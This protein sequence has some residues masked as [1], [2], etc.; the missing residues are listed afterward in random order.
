MRQGVVDP[1]FTFTA[2]IDILHVPYKGAGPAIA[3]VV[4]GHVDMIFINP[5]LVLGHVTTGKLRPL[6]TIGNDRW[7]KM[8]QVPTF[9][10][11][12][13]PSIDLHGIWTIAAPAKI[14]QSHVDVL[15]IAFKKAIELPAMRDQLDE[16]ALTIVGSDPDQSAIRLKR[17]LE[18]WG[19][20]V[21][22]SGTKAD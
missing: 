8:P 21:K 1:R 5:G 13:L 2:G 6:A 11:A 3:D 9:G 22:A 7:S 20:A 18:R 4:A 16:L 15:Y 17:E 12:G 14:M 19:R 10:E